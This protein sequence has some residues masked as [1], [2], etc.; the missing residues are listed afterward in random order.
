MTLGVPD[1]WLADEIEA[2]ALN[3]D[4]RGSDLT[5]VTRRDLATTRRVTARCRAQVI[6]HRRRR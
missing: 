3:Q 6:W 5:V 4:A 2:D 1:G